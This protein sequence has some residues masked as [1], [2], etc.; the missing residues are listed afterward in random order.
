MAAGVWAEPPARC[1]TSGVTIG[2]DTAAG[3]GSAP[4]N[5]IGWTLTGI[6]AALVSVAPLATDM[7]LPGFPAMASDLAT[8]ASGV[9]LTLT[10]FLLG[11]AAGQLVLGPVSD[12]WGRRGPL[13]VATLVCAAAGAV[14]ALAPSLSVL[15]VARVV[16]GFTGAGG[17]VIGRAVV[18]DLVEGRAAAKSFTLMFTVAGVA[19]VLAPLMGSLLIGP[20]GWRG[21]LWVVAGLGV[22]TFLA[23]VFGLRE[24]QPPGLRQAAREASTVAAL[25]VVVRTSGYWVPTLVSVA[26]FATLM[27]YI[28]ASPFVYQDVMGLSEVGYGVAFGVNAVGI[29]AAGWVAGRLLDRL[30]PRTIARAATLLQALASLVFLACALVEAPRLLYAV[31]I[32][33]A[34]VSVGGIMGNASALAMSRVREVAGMGSAV[35]GFTQFLAGALVSPLVGLGGARSAVAPA[36][37]MTMTAGLGALLARRLAPAP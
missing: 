13:L 30:G 20:I 10:A 25:R 21:I 36:L 14:T 22:L 19:P 28:S 12:R 9:Q 31:P 15:L 7:Y 32:F 24:T 35:L 5:P 1:C 27:A 11:M 26:C 8:S 2:E 17:M 18:A 37:V 16:Q 23:V 29:T 3:R 34:V 6:L 4:A 33:L